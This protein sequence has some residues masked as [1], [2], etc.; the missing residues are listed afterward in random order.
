MEISIAFICIGNSCRSQMA[1]G[2][3]KHYLSEK[4]FKE[5]HKINIYSAGTFPALKISPDAITVMQEKGIDIS[6]Q[7]PKTL[8]DIPQEID[9]LITM[10]CGVECPYLS[11]KHRIDWGIDDPV[12]L[13]IEL[14]RKISDT[15]ENKVLN[16]VDTIKSSYS[17]QD[18]INKLSKA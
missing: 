17:L 1:E 13:P 16:L 12:G 11:S 15:I 14:F 9:I 10:G 2:F 8:D 7:Y 18:V 6:K 3:A 5:K 4:N